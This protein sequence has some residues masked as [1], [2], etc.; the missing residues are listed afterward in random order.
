MA[1]SEHEPLKALGMI[2]PPAFLNEQALN[3][4]SRG[5]G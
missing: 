2:E 4:I 3:E 1:L 5:G